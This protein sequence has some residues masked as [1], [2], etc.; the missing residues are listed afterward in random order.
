MESNK[1]F[2]IT[3]IFMIIIIICLLFIY[4]MDVDGNNISFNKLFTNNRVINPKTNIT[5]NNTNNKTTTKQTELSR[6]NDYKAY[7]SVNS[8]IN[9]YY[10]HITNGNYSNAIGLLD[11]YY[12]MN[13]KITNSNIKNFVKTGYQDITYYSKTM[14]VKKNGYLSYYF[15]DGEEQL[16]DFINEIL[17]E[18]EHVMYMVIVDNKRNT[19][20]ITPLKTPSFMDYANN[21]NASSSKEITSNAY[22]TYF[23]DDIT[24]DILCSYYINYFK[25]LLFLNTEKAYNMLDDN[26]K[27]RFKDYEDFVNNLETIYNNLN[28]KVSYYSI[29]GDNGKR[30]Y[31]IISGNDIIV[32]ITESSIFNYKIS[33][34]KN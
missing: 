26:Y 29:D 7:F 16:Y 5:S 33:I 9:K 10:S 24:D 13:N 22:N 32:D 15:V 1:N 11:N 4:F 28:T 6:V 14:Y 19:F 8:L 21:Y 20:S 30:K 34:D 17:T 23:S 2:I 18:E 12:V 25:T 31:S 27:K 3:L